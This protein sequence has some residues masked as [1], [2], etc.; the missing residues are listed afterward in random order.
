MATCVADPS[1]KTTHNIVTN[2]REEGCVSSHTADRKEVQR[3][4]GSSHEGDGLIDKSFSNSTCPTCFVIVFAYNFGFGEPL[5]NFLFG[6]AVLCWE[7]AALGLAPGPGPRKCARP[8]LHT[9]ANAGLGR[10]GSTGSSPPGGWGRRRG[11]GAIGTRGQGAG[12]SLPAAPRSGAQGLLGDFFRTG[13]VTQRERSR[14]RM[15]AFGQKMR[16]PGHCALAFG[17]REKF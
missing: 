4:L 5:I 17:P 11:N 7:L 12:G 6:L 15:P 16:P 1:R 8:T 10:P 3:V 13:I 2:P 14:T 9:N